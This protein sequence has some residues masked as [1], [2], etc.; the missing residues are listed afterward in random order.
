M[1]SQKYQVFINIKLIQ[2]GNIN[3]FYKCRTDA[4]VQ[5]NENQCKLR[6]KQSNTWLK[7]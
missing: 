4:Y 3:A 6:K 2:S 1:K 5:L 7:T